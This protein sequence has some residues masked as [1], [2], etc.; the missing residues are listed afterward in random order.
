MYLVLMLVMW[1]DMSNKIRD[2]ADRAWCIT[3][4][5][6][7]I[8]DLASLLVLMVCFKGVYVRWRSTA[9]TIGR[10]LLVVFGTVVMDAVREVQAVSFVL[11]GRPKATFLLKVWGLSHSLTR[12][13]SVFGCMVG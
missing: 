11:P 1:L 10:T 2:D 4:C 9:M 6:L 8:C 5:K 12:V 7:V 3:L 13:L